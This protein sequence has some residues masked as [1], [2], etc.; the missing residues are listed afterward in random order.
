M[1]EAGGQ[2]S[3]GGAAAGA[4]RW[5]SFL[6][7][8]AG[9]AWAFAHNFAEMWIRWFPAWNH[10][11]QGLYGRI[12]GGES[13]YTH[14]PLVPMISLFIGM[15][16]VRHTRIP[17]RP[18]VGAGLCVVML[19]LLLHLAACLARVNF[20]SGFAFIFVLAGLVLLLWGWQALRRLW[21]PL[22]FLGFMVP[23]P[24]V[25][26]ANLNFELKMMASRLGVGIAG[27]LG[28]LVERDG[29]RVLLQGDK[30]LVIA[31]V[32]NGLRTLISLLGFGA[33]YAYVCR[34]R[35]L[36]RLGLFAMTIPVAVASNA[37]RVVGLIVV[38]DVWD[39]PTATG[40]FH[41]ISGIFIYL[42]AFLLMFGLEKAVLGFRRLLGRSAKI[43]AL[44]HDVRRGPEDEGQA[45]RLLD[46]FGLR[47]AFM[48]VALIVLG[49]LGSRHLNQSIP[50]TWNAAV[51]AQS[52][53]EALAVQGRM[54][55]GYPRELDDNTLTILETR[56]YLYRRY[57]GAGT[58]AVDFCVIFS[59]DNRK[60]T[61]PPDLCLQGSG[62]G[63]LSKADR[64]IDGVDGRGA[65]ACRELIVQ[66]G[67]RRQYILYTYKCGRE[68][69]S[70]FWKQQWTILMNGL[71]KRDSGGALIRVSM[72]IGD[73][74]ADARGDAAQFLRVCIPYLDRTLKVQE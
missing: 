64:M 24:E 20:A 29:N 28:V 32:C 26:I 51:A 68:Y 55:H 53:P 36:E 43:L 45:R 54:L 3:D 72:P 49:V 52:V 1:S 10:A 2:I 63:I 42:V 27:L 11:N 17:A 16:L 25:L 44:F 6:A 31:N 48:C 19:S 15:M 7:I 12:V 50:S 8:T 39:V 62:D 61:H 5:V 46:A 74:V 56:D 60:G 65:V 58:P 37:L 33:L 40:K 67:S 13:Y 23:L 70:S 34:L 14:A 18:A 41:D 22:A 4:W 30:V 47:P 57:V 9:L 69:T 73:R 71:F 38:A 21:F 59:Q 35:G 66:S